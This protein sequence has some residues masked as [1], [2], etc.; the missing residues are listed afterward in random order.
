M[1]PADAPA[2]PAPVPSGPKPAP[3]GAAPTLDEFL[4]RWRRGKAGLKPATEARLDDCLTILRRY[5]DTSRPV[6]DYKSQDIRDYL[7]QA[8]ADKVKG[9]RRLKGQTINE[10]I[11]RLLHNAFA[12]ALEE[13]FIERNP[14]DSVDREKT[15]PITRTQQTLED[16]QRI[17]EDV[18]SRNLESYLEL[19]FML[20]LGVG[21][22]E[23]KGATGDSINWQ[24]EEVSFIRKKTGKPYE[25]PFYPWAKDFLLK[26]IQPRARPGKP[27]FDWRNPRKALATA[28]HNLGLASVDVRSL[29]RTLIIHLLQRGTEIRVIADWQGHRDAT[30]I[31]KVYGKYIDADHKKRALMMLGEAEGQK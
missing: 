18:K 6:P 22:A 7:A 24:A 12:L 31:L 21:Q 9:R 19:R 26:E 29:R 5:V 16:A 4:N 11:W 23:A 27:L 10:A 30:L 14:M 3:P 28:C 25:V 20:V 15:T 1:V 17:L 8:R 13:R 2:A